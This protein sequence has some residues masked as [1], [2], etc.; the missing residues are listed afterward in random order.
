MILIAERING[1]FTDVKQADWLW[2]FRWAHA[3]SDKKVKVDGTMEYGFAHSYGGGSKGDVTVEMH[4]TETDD[5]SASRYFFEF[6]RDRWWLVEHMFL[7]YPL[8]ISLGA[9]LGMGAVKR[10]LGRT[11][12][13]SSAIMTNDLGSKEAGTAEVLRLVGS[14]IYRP[15]ASGVVGAT[16]DI[17]ALDLLVKGLTGKKKQEAIA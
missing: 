5:V 6:D 17:A 9:V 11:L 14:G 8:P 15:R 10:R 7:D 16:V 3:R 1:M 2:N 4:D 13:K 12:R